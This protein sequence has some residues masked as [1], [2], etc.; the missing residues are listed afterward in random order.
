MRL[1][2]RLRMVPLKDVEYDI[3]YLRASKHASWLH[4]AYA[5]WLLQ[6]CKDPN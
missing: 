6:R 5:A 3:R 2:V 4:L 1:S